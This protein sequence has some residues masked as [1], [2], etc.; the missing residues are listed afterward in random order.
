[1]NVKVKNQCYL[2]GFCGI[3]G[4]VAGTVTWLFL[5][6]MEV[7]Q[8]FLWEV[9]AQKAGIQ[10]YPMLVAIFGGLLI[11]VLRYVYG[12]YPKELDYVIKKVKTDN[13]YEYHP[14][15]IML[16]AALLP[17]LFG[18]SIGPEAGLAGILVSLCYWAKDNIKFAQD[19]AKEYSQVGMA[20]T[21]SVLFHSP[22]FG[23]FAVEESDSNEDTQI[24]GGKKMLL[25]GT[26]ILA[27]VA[28]YL[29]LSRFFG[30]VLGGMPSFSGVT[31][32]VRDYLLLLLY[33]PAGLLLGYVYEK[34][35]WI[36]SKLSKDVPPIVRETLV[37]AILGGVALLNPI[38]LFSGEK[39]MGQVLGNPEMF[40]PLMFI[41]LGIGK[42]CLTNLCIQFGWKGG[43]FFPVIFA[44]MLVGY[45]VSG[46]VTLEH[47]AAFAAAIVTA[48]ML[49]AM[50]K[51][52]LAVTLLLLICFPISLVVWI[53]V[54]AVIGSNVSRLLT[55]KET[56]QNEVI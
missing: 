55:K 34:S 45:G 49:G 22:L 7:G 48:T 14:M 2:I 52:P 33:L 9:L 42:V 12:D 54:A 18:G 31:L 35:H 3:L 30:E 17:L 13:H 26:A 27:A 38:L 10:W 40:P 46:F 11:G 25:Y 51:K 4:A 19:H 16:I 1:M 8:W 44:G 15:L 56:E 28:C 50:M 39:E 53:F 36:C 41:T 24:P 47:Q 21:L 32:S 23:I 43:H 20:V 37:G 6:A 29:I 5:K